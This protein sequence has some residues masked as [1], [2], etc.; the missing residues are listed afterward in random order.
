MA[1]ELMQQGL[2][3]F[4]GYF[5]APGCWE[6]LTEKQDFNMECA[7]FVL[8]RGLSLGIVAGA[9]LVKVPQI[10][11][12]LR[13]QSV[14]GIS[15]AGYLLETVLYLNNVL[16]N[17]YSGYPISTW[18]EYIFLFFQNSIICYIYF[19]F[20]GTFFI[21]GLFSGILGA[22]GLGL[23]NN[24]IQLPL[25][26]TVQQYNAP[27]F[28][29]SKAPQIYDNFRNGHTGTLSFATVFLLFAGSSARC[30]TIIKEVDD[31][32]ILLQ[33]VVGVVLNGLV[34]AQVLWY[35]EATAEEMKKLDTKKKQ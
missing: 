2:E 6:L 11:T 25:L 7:S 5:F 14:E 15:L 35:R 31:P 10:V 20:E 17:W 18:A 28:A 34:V 8:S 26:R 29:I 19:A 12:C 3:L 30:F 33:A 9:S 32:I 1:A 22:V 24:S 16:Y 23:Q 4:K 21:G 13:L 27:L